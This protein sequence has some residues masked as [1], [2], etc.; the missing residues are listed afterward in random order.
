MVIL[1]IAV[2]EI[3]AIASLKSNIRPPEKYF[4]WPPV[5]WFPTSLLWCAWM[6][7]H[8]CNTQVQMLLFTLVFLLFKPIFS[9][10]LQTQKT[11][12]RYCCE[13][14][15]SYITI[16]NDPLP[17]E[18]HL[19]FLVCLLFPVLRQHDGQHPASSPAE[20]DTSKPIST[21][22]YSLHIILNSF[23]FRA[24]TM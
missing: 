5:V 15:I 11:V 8:R 12:Q 22:R 6:C 19:S 17:S 13:W 3:L 24:N 7:Q 2:I 14:N 20:I 23:K 16:E 18:C 21:C 1:N 4:F 9:W 10:V